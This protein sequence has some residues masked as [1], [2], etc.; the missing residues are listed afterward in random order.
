[1]ED[2]LSQ[3]HHTENI[4]H[5]IT[6]MD[7]SMNAISTSVSM[8]VCT[9]IEDIWEETQEGTHLQKLNSYI[10]QGLPLEKT[11]WNIEEDNTGQLEV[12]IPDWWHCC[13]GKNNNKTFSIA[14]ANTVPIMQSLN[15][16]WKKDSE[17]VSVLGENEWIHLK[18][19]ETVCHMLQVPTNKPHEKKIPYEVSCLL[20]LSYFSLTLTVQLLTLYF[21]FYYMMYGF[22]L[23]I[24]NKKPQVLTQ[25]W[26]IYSGLCIWQ[27]SKLLYKN[28]RREGP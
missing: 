15:G 14:E 25:C 9:S 6:G 18:H 27:L 22:S 10:I 1:M 11:K 23:K 4:D 12:S 20:A 2:W 16:H 3:I 13:E 28:K 17:E 7:I 19:C 21:S 24:K 8:P 5:V 26:W